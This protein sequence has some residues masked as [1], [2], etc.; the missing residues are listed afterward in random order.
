MKYFKSFLLLLLL[1]VLPATAVCQIEIYNSSTTIGAGVFKT[2]KNVRLTATAT[3][4][5]YS[6]ISGHDQGDK[7][8]GT[9][10]L[11]SKMYTKN[12]DIGAQSTSCNSATYDFSSQNWT[13]Q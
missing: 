3:S 5:A 2:S 6:A 8:Y 4:N 7:E 1:M 11:D 10:H 12:K 13:A 9:Q